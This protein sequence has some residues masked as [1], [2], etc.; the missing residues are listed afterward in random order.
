MKVNHNSHYNFD[1]RIKSKWFV[2]GETK[3]IT[4]RLLETRNRVP[5]EIKTID[6]S[7]GLVWVKH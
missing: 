7:S 2:K 6:E 4:N 5:T 3:S 1:E